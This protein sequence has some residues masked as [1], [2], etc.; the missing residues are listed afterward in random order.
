MQSTHVKHVVAYIKKLLET[1]YPFD[2]LLFPECL[3]FFGKHSFDN[4]SQLILIRFILHE[5]EITREELW[6]FVYQVGWKLPLSV[7]KFLMREEK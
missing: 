4:M 2:K 6:K 3:H 7:E 1:G 5:L